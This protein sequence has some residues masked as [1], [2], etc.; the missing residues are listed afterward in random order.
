MNQKVIVRHHHHRLRKINQPKIQRWRNPRKLR[1]ETTVAVRPPDL[2]LPTRIPLGSVRLVNVDVRRLLVS[3]LHHVIG[4][5]VDR[6]HAEEN[7]H[8]GGESLRHAGESPRHAEES[9]R[10]AGESRR[11]A[12]ENPHHAKENLRHA[13]ENL[14]PDNQEIPDVA[15]N[16]PK[17]SR[18]DADANH[19]R[20]PFKH[21]KEERDLTLQSHLQKNARKVHLPHRSQHVLKHAKKSLLRRGHHHLHRKLKRKRKR[22]KNQRHLHQSQKGP[23]RHN[24]LVARN[25]G[26]SRQKV[27]KKVVKVGH[28]LSHHGRANRNARKLSHVLLNPNHLP[29]SLKDPHLA[30][31]RGEESTLPSLLLRNGQIK[32]VH[33]LQNK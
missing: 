7:R 4:R 28:R 12:E 18:R 30:L 3:V 31:L 27:R 16:R 23:R 13:E 11:H 32:I 1:T 14:R 20:H 5:V 15:D 2:P 10:H 26:R 8:R 6:L 19:R 17:T 33:L 29:V 22:K 25:S 9:L 24:Q 21:R